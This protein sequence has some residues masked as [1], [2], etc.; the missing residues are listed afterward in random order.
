MLPEILTVFNNTLKKYNVGTYI[1]SYPGLSGHLSKQKRQATAV[2][3]TDQCQ[4]AD[5]DLLYYG[6]IKIRDKTFQIDFDTGSSDLFVPGPNCG[7]E[8]GCA[9]TNKYDAAGKDLGNTTS[10]TYGSGQ[11]SGKNYLDTVTIG[12]LSAENT[13]VISLDQAKG[14]SDIAS[15]GLMGMVSHN[16]NTKIPPS[17]FSLQRRP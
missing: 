5:N 6:P 14:F 10:V 12:N 8:Q 15:D 11:V 7:T 3:L 4:P 16:L 1:K 17:H 2:P 13:N 9:G